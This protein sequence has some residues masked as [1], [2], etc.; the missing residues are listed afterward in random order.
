VFLYVADGPA[1]GSGLCRSE[2]QT[3]NRFA[4]D[5]WTEGY[6]SM[7]KRMLE[8]GIVDDVVVII[9][10][11]RSIGKLSLGDNFEIH[12]V[13][14]LGACWRDFCNGHTVFFVRSGYRS[15]FIP[16][17]MMHEEGYHIVFYRAASN[18]G[19]WLVWDTVLDDLTDGPP[20]VDREGRMYLPFHKPMNE[21]LFFWEGDHRQYDVCVGASHIHDK[22]GQW[23]A[24]DAALV[25]QQKYGENLR[26]VMPGRVTGGRKTR[27]MIQKICDQ[28]LPITFPGMVPRDV[29]RSIYSQSVCMTHWG[30]AGQNDRGPLEALCCGTPVMI[31]NLRYHPPW[32]REESDAVKHSPLDDEV[33]DTEMRADLIYDHLQTFA[34]IDRAG[35]RAYYLQKN[36]MEQ[37]TIP[38]MKK[39]FDFL[40]ENPNCSRE[41]L[42]DFYG[43]AV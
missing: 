16:L 18:R 24:I 34:A 19:P 9:E 10:S 22:K 7:L 39:L 38:E 40:R 20:C 21:D 5:F 41:D 4:L 3:S 33:F 32:M 6:C 25:Y 30:G 8:L 26:L 17:S 2:G 12:V 15:W 27:E 14:D 36:G 43:A 11:T 1:P 23:K 35:V 31:Q 13:P 42:W 28:Q 29:L 37:H